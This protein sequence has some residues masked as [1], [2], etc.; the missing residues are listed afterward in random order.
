M[1]TSIN[2]RAKAL[3]PRNA[4]P[5]EL[6]RHDLSALRRDVGRMLGG[7]LDSAAVRTR[8]AVD[9]A[10][11]RVAELAEQ[12]REKADEAHVKLAETAGSRPITTILV[13]V[14]AGMVIGKLL[15]AFARR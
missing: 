4:D 5:I 7:S 13:S 15:G 3:D 1:K 6:L 9:A 8:D 10:K 2:G 12:G 11:E 14:A